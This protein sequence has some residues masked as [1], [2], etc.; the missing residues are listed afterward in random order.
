MAQGGSGARR[1]AWVAWAAWAGLAL[2]GCGK[3]TREADRRALPPG[4][5]D[6]SLIEPSLTNMIQHCPVTPSSS[7]R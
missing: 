5:P 3:D 7:C 6:V 1:V 4:V 2:A